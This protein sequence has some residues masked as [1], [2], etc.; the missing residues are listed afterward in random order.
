MQALAK[1]PDGKSIHL[2]HSTRVYDAHAIGL[3]ERDAKASGVALT[4]LSDER[5]GKLNAQRIA[6]Q[7]PDWR[8]ADLWFCGPAP[9]GQ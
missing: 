5:D 6:K 2:F 1:K 7:V 8:D 4:V 3:M 9:F